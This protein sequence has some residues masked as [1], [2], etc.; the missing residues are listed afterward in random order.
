MFG[1][2]YTGESEVTNFD[3]ERVVLIDVF[4]IEFEKFKCSNDLNI[5]DFKKETATVIVSFIQ[6]PKSF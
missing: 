3:A 6:E 1:V 2:S 4:K 5:T